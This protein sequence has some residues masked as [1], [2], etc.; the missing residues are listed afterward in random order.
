[1]LLSLGNLQSYLIIYNLPTK[2]CTVMKLVKMGNEVSHFD[3]QS[4]RYSILPQF[5]ESK[6]QHISCIFMHW[7]L[8]FKFAGC[9]EACVAIPMGK[10]IDNDSTMIIW[11]NP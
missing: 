1:M 5:Q 9:G 11:E 10:A 8:L 2:M 7:Y 3:Y 6:S 4:Q